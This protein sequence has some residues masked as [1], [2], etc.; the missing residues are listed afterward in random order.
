MSVWNTLNEPQRRV[1]CVAII[2]QLTGQP[3]TQETNRSIDA[4]L[5]MLNEQMVGQ[6]SQKQLNDLRARR[7]VFKTGSSQAT[8]PTQAFHRKL[9]VEIPAGD[10]MRDPLINAVVNCLYLGNDPNPAQY[11][12][13]SRANLV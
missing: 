11:K 7:S 13:L 6:M 2:Q 1:K 4:A 12:L 5:I 10:P 3:Q 8:T 9:G